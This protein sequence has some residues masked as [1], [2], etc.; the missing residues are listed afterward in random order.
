MAKPYGHEVDA[1][2]GQHS[3]QTVWSKDDLADANRHVE[4]QDCH[5]SHRSQPGTHS[6][7]TN[8]ASPA[9]AAIWG[10]EPTVAGWDVVDPAA[11]E[12]Q[13]CL[14]CHS[15]YAAGAPSDIAA[16]TD[17]Q[18]ASYHPV[19]APGKNPTIPS[20]TFVAPWTAG[21]EMYC[22]DCHSGEAGEAGPHGSTNEW[23]LRAPLST[24][25]FWSGDPEQSMGL[26]N[27]CH[28]SSVYLDGGAGSAFGEHSKHVAEE[29]ITCTTC[30][31]SHGRTDE[32]H[33]I[34]LMEPSESVGNLAFV[35]DETGGMC[36]ATCHNAES[37]QHQ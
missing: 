9:L 37:Y 27:T 4:C 13:V 18:N 5:S 28:Q 36:A 29:G 22:S 1:Y 6:P 24:E 33:L 3:P 32:A 10:V 16:A 14:K 2:M 15:S 19:R 7:G 8:D 25:P 23:I 35:H 26:C 12:Y 11:K 30:H 34:R 31:A 21:S 17:P 20:S